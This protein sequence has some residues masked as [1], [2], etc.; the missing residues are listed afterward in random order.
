[1][2]IW[3]GREKVSLQMSVK[4]VWKFCLVSDKYYG[5]SVGC[6]TLGLVM[7]THYCARLHPLPHTSNF[8]VI[9]TYRAMTTLCQ[10]RSDGK[11]GHW[12]TAEVFLWSRP[13]RENL[14]GPD[15][16]QSEP[17]RV[18]RSHSGGRK[19]VPDEGN[20][21]TYS[22]TTGAIKTLAAPLK[23]QALNSTGVSSLE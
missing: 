2:I 15:D 6:P 14:S 22:E 11:C 4:T 12:G 20:Y 3:E 13:G 5:V 10:M 8:A 16:V 1:M 19:R 23:L 9:Q 7:E 18:W 21:I 17:Q